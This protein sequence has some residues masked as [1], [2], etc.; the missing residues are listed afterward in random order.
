MADSKIQK[1]NE[2]V[3]GRDPNAKPSDSPTGSDTAKQNY[4]AI[5][6]GNDKGSIGFGI[7]HQAAD[8]TSSVMLQT[9]DANHSFFLDGD[10][11]RK[12]WTTSIGPGNFQVECGSAN[13]EAQES[14]MLNAKNGNI[15]IKAN[16]GKI[17]IEGT[18]IELIAIGEGG[19][20]GNIRL[21][22][23]ENISA[24]SKKIVMNAKASYRIATSGVGE[25]VA[26]SI[27]KCYGSIFKMIDDSVVEKDAK[28][29]GK[30]DAEKNN[31]CP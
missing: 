28:N 22:A 27:L 31:T 15:T 3:T 12:G 17:R 24:D 30:R 14:L 7:I 8:V 26:K 29:G 1:N 10:G 18:D 9:P 6:Y 19:S 23:S 13:K 2:L 21:T 4:T 11:K 5:T 16:N 20:K 25:V